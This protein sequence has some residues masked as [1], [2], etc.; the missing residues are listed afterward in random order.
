MIIST[1]ILLIS[2]VLDGILSNFLPFLVNDLSLFTP[3]LTV[4]AIFMIYPF[5]RKKEKKYF[6]TIFIVG[7]IYDLLY[8]NLVF[9]NG[10]LFLI[11]GFISLEIY[12]N[13]EISYLKLIIYLIL[14]ISAYEILT[15][16]ILLVF[17]MVPVT[18]Y[19]VLYKIT[20]SLILNIIYGE[21]IYLIINLIPKK[22]RKI[23]IN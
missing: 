13:F 11:I 2:I 6:I 1:I 20:H 17:N 9:F 4:I 16:I 7:M 19:K 5:F 22:Y 14:I 3:M 18:L 23:S 10:V 8:T 15:G 21:L 12:K